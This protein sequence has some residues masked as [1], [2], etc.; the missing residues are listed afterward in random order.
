[1]CM[2]LSQGVNLQSLSLPERK[3]S[4]LDYTGRFPGSMPMWIDTLRERVENTQDCCGFLPNS[5]ARVEITLL[6]SFVMN[7]MLHFDIKPKTQGRKRAKNVCFHLPCITLNSSHT[8]FFQT[9]LL[10]D[11]F[12]IC[13]VNSIFNFNPYILNLMKN[14]MYFFPH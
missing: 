10:L 4:Y 3:W 9:F 2:C 14:S 6:Y 8:V 13:I 5:S 7:L 11:F 1:M 12:L